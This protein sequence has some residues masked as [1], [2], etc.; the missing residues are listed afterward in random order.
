MTTRGIDFKA[1]SL[2]DAL[3]LAVLVEEEAKER[4]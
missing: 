1:L 3:D 4:Y 2:K